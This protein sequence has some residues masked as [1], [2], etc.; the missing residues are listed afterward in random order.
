MIQFFRTTPPTVHQMVL[1]LEKAGLTQAGR[2][3]K[4]RGSARTVRLARPK[5]ERRSTSQNHCDEV[6]ALP[7]EKR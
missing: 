2:P 7:A 1:S 5:S 4:Y 6:L 3:A